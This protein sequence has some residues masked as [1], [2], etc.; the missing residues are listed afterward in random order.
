MNGYVTWHLV[1]NQSKTLNDQSHWTDDGSVLK[2]AVQLVLQIFP[3]WGVGGGCYCWSL[4]SVASFFLS[5][6]CSPYF[7]L[8]ALPLPL[9][10]FFP[11][12]QRIQ[13]DVFV[14]LPPFH[15]I[16]MIR[17]LLNLINWSITLQFIITASTIKQPDKPRA[18]AQR[19]NIFIMYFRQ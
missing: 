18:R 14:C 2:T 11:K 13:R 15:S 1:T 16:K 10:H 12:P 17:N 3:L 4:S 9:F 6:F 7:P 19:T 8:L 5:G